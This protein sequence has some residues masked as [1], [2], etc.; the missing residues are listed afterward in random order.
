MN[1][2]KEENTSILNEKFDGNIPEYDLKLIQK[3]KNI[4]LI[5]ILSYFL[6]YHF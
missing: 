1:P 2:L 3:L 4:F 5:I 6:L